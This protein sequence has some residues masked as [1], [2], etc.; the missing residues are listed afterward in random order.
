MKT[1]LI[2]ESETPAK[3]EDRFARQRDLVPM[4]RLLQVGCTVIGVGAIG[5]QAA[6]RATT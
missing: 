3:P 2:Q 4:E 5:R 6:A 1:L